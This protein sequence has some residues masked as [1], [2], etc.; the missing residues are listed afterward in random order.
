MAVVTSLW[1]GATE[2]VAHLMFGVFALFTL[3]K[4]FRNGIGLVR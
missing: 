3:W 4:V 1:T 2:V